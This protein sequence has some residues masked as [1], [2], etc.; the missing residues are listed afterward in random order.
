MNR[1][2][3]WTLFGVGAVGML[4]GSAGCTCS[5]FTVRQVQDLVLPYEWVGNIDKS[6]I[7]EPSGI[8]Y[9]PNRRTLFVVSDEGFVCEMATD[10]TQIK[11][12]KVRDADFEGIT[13]DPATGLLYL[14]IEGEERILEVE[15]DGFAV[16]REFQLDRYLDGELVFKPGG[17]GIE[18]I[19]F[20]PDPRN[21]E[22]GTFYVANQS[23]TLEPGEER[24]LIAEVQL[25]LK[26]S[27]ERNAS[28]RILRTF[29]F[30]VIDLSAISYNHTTGTLFVVS[31]S[32]NTLCEMDRNANILLARAFTGA[33]Q[34]GIALDDEG[35]L[36]IAQDSGGIIKIRPLWPER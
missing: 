2:T 34:E 26:T 31:D 6:D 15:P 14:A 33:D 18:G 22:G 17:Q 10:G 28:G 16:L 30:G 8:V 12:Q 25:P 20:V 1:I 13:Q 9:D 23:F 27:S 7:V 11:M 5:P 21:P 35:F 36:Y 24:S 29:P 4:L 3:S 19:A 32:M